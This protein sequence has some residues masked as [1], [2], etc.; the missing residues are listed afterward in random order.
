MGS[1]PRLYNTLVYGFSPYQN[2]VELR[3][4]TTLA[5]MVVG[6]MPSGKISLTAWTPSGHR[7]AV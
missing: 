7:R 1:P 5:R 3:Y 2:W 6:L 4:L